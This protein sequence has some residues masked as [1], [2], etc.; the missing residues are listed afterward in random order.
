MS[1][2]RPR[3]WTRKEFYAME[4]LG[5]FEGQ[6]VEMV[7]GEIVEMSPQNAL[8]ASL[9]ER[10][11]QLL[12]QCFG[13]N[14]IVRRHSPLSLPGHSEPEPDIAVVHG[15]TEDFVEKHPTS[16]VLV[17][18]IS[19]SS[20]AHDRDRKGPVYARAD[21]QEYWIANLRE[22][23]LEVYR[24]PRRIASRG[25]NYG[26]Q[27]NYMRGDSV[28]PLALPKARIAVSDLFLKK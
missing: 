10:F 7:E 2:P 14:Y 9:T 23:L 1:E 3:K 17:V 28:V 11:A 4:K 22:D 27:T 21:I 8:H 18:E 13:K 20:L 19:L 16:A 25:W 12:Q 5:L 15:R 24:Q 26:A 6:H